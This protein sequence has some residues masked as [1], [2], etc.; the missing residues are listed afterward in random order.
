VVTHAP[1]PTPLLRSLRKNHTLVCD[2]PNAPSKR[3]S[4]S[5][6]P[7][8]DATAERRQFDGHAFEAV[9]GLESLELKSHP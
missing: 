5:K 9:I 6:Q 3:T 8:Y 2:T 7:Q 1:T 4:V